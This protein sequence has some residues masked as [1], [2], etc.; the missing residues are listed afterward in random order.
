M[1]S[2]DAAAQPWRGTFPPHVPRAGRYQENA[3]DGKRSPRSGS[4][5]P[6]GKHDLGI[7]RSVVGSTRDPS[8]P[9]SSPQLDRRVRYPPPRSRRR[10]AADARIRCTRR[11]LAGSAYGERSAMFAAKCPCGA[12][13]K[14][15]DDA[16][17]KQGKC[18]RCNTRFVLSPWL[19]CPDCGVD[20]TLNADA[21]FSCR[22]NRHGHGATRIVGPVGTSWTNSTTRVRYQLG[23]VLHEACAACLRSSSQIGA[24]WGIPWSP[25]CACVQRAVR[26]GQNGRP[27]QAGGGRPPNLGRPGD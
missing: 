15:P 26:V 17:G 16:V 6:N 24:V 2:P 1:V 8:E 7:C 9:Y 5:L 21:S 3:S 22:C 14:A 11:S 27:A 18:P 12:K 10:P 25:K 4:G 13:L 23:V 20:I 19:F